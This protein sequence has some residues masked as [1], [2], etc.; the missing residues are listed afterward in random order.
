MLL[1]S[2]SGCAGLG[3]EEQPV[4]PRLV[5]GFQD[6]R[7]RSRQRHETVG[8]IFCDV[9]CAFYFDYN[10]YICLGITPNTSI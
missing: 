4:G 10:Q 6:G 8:R 9:L 3:N 5:P 1:F 7:P 2:T